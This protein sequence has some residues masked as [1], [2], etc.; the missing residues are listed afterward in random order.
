MPIIIKIFEISIRL[1]FV[2]SAFIAYIGF[3]WFPNQSNILE[4]IFATD[5]LLIA[6]L[7]YKLINKILYI[8]LNLFGIFLLCYLIYSSVFSITL[9]SVVFYLAQISGFIL[10][11]FIS[12]KRYLLVPK[13]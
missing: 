11:I 2:F 8:F 6:V 3:M 4:L 13:L 7:S 10:L 9:Q 12:I 1:L 5:L